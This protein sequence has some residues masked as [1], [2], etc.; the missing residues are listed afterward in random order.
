[1]ADV[2]R[3]YVISP[4]VNV[5]NYVELGTGLPENIVLALVVECNTIVIAD[6]VY[7]TAFSGYGGSM[8]AE[9]SLTFWKSLTMT[10]HM[11][12]S[13]TARVTSLAACACTAENY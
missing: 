4:W 9:S 3:G 11:P 8:L 7:P 5:N 10:P 1:M 2:Y 6:L 12:S 13:F